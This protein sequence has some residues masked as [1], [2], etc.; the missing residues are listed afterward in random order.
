MVLSEAEKRDAYR[1][2]QQILRLDAKWQELMPGERKPN[3]HRAAQEI[4]KRAL[5][6]RTGRNE[7]AL[8]IHSGLMHEHGPR[9]ARLIERTLRAGHLHPDVLHSFQ[10]GVTKGDPKPPARYIDSDFAQAQYGDDPDLPDVDVYVHNAAESIVP[11]SHYEPGT[12]K[13]HAAHHEADSHVPLPDPLP[14]P[15]QAR[16]PNHYEAVGGP[17]QPQPMAAAPTYPQLRARVPVPRGPV[18]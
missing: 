17:Q 11:A 2:A 10:H 16:L 14:A 8:D 12:G 6:H 7:E 5:G 9:E 4:L 1:E 3:F 15:P 18:R 13:Y